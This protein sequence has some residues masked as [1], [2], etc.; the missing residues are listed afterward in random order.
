MVDALAALTTPAADGPINLEGLNS[1]FPFPAPF[2]RNAILSVNSSS[3]SP[4]FSQAKPLERNMSAITV[5]MRVLAK[6]TS[7][8]TSKLSTF[9]ASTSIRA[10]LQK[11]VSPLPRMTANFLTWSTCLHRNYIIPSLSTASAAP[12]STADTTVFLCSIAA[13]MSCSSEEAENQNKLQ[14]E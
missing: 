13:R 7:M 8:H 4:W 3:P 5:R 9:G 1:F 2:L 6:K 14:R 10:K 12:A 11:L